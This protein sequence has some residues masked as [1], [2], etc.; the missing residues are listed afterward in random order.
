VKLL[1]TGGGTGGHVYPALAIAEALSEDGAFAPLDVLF[2]GTRGGLEASIVP[3]AGLPTAFV[4]ALS[5]AVRERRWVFSVARRGG[6][7]QA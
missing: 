2:V 4:S 5:H 1:L 3:K 7:F 6:T